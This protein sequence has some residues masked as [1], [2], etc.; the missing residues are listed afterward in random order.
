MFMPGMNRFRNTLGI[1][2]FQEKHCWHDTDM[3]RGIGF[4]AGNN[5][6]L[7]SQEK[8]ITPIVI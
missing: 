4:V 1:R 8:R 6:S 2:H 3:H 5:R 7:G